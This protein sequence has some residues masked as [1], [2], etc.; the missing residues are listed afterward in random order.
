MHSDA[1]QIFQNRIWLPDQNSDRVVGYCLDN[2]KP[3]VSIKADCFDFPHGLGISPNGILAV[4]N[5]GGSSIALMNISQI[6]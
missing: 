4:T 6:Q 1:C 3:A 2:T 5:Y